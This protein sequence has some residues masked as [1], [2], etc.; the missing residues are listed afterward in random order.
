MA[1]C[2]SQQQLLSLD[3]VALPPHALTRSVSASSG[4]EGL[5]RG[6]SQHDGTTAAPKA[7]R[8]RTASPGIQELMQWM[9]DG[10]GASC[11]LLSVP[12]DRS[13]Q[14]AGSSVVASVDTDTLNALATSAAITN[15]VRLLPL[16][17]RPGM[18]GGRVGLLQGLRTADMDKY[19]EVGV[20]CVICVCVVVNQHQISV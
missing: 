2:I 12:R 8:Q 4:S 14:H 5:G 18:T 17:L 11:R 3:R 6:R 1:A 15:A 20:W 10:D 7:L 13:S 19:D 9:A 16:G